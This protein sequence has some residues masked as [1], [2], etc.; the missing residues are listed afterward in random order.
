M[1]KAGKISLSLAIAGSVVAVRVIFRLLTG[2]TFDDAFITY[3][4]AEHLAAGEGFVYNLGKRVLGTTTPLFTLLLAALGKIGL[5][6]ESAAL[7]IALLA[8]AITGVILYRY[9]RALGFGSF[10]LLPVVAYVFFPRLLPVDSGG[11]E[12][13]LFTLLVTAALYARFRQKNITAIA[14]A[15]LSVLTRPEG[16]IVWGL[17][18]IASLWEKQ[19]DLGKQAAVSAFLILPWLLFAWRCFGSPIPN[20]VWAKM[21]LYHHAWTKPFWA[22]L[23][24]L[25]GWHHPFGW[26]LFIAAIIGAWWLR[27]QQ[28]LGW[29]E[30][31]WVTAMIVFYLAG[32]TMIFR[33]YIAPIYPVYLLLAS[34]ALLVLREK[35]SLL[36]LSVA[37]AFLVIG[38]S[39]LLILAN[40]KTVHN[41]R[42]EWN[43]LSTIHSGIV[44]FLQTHAAPDD[45]VATEDIGY[46][47]Y[48]SRLTILDRAGLVSPEVIPY[49]KRQDYF[50]VIRDFRPAW[51]I[52]SPSDPTA[53]FLQQPEFLT[54]YEE[55]AVFASPS[56]QSWEFVVFRRKM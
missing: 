12:T 28:K 5:P 21:A 11:M 25:M 41:Y 8:S 52:I 49:H 36:K 54:L 13:A 3:R 35:L 33:W 32:S 47:G 56:G 51:L 7:G 16:W 53:V 6:F 44:R 2:F 26:V 29:L 40:G 55:R 46:V 17:L 30:I 20:T 27:K 18:I 19:K 24:L 43:D 48:Y 14:L 45:V 23:V 38:G 34:A 10:A 39:L 4:Y 37:P 42:K 22:R 31:T 50:G 1:T 15:S 9:A